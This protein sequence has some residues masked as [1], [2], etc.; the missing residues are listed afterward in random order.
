MVIRRAI[1]G[2]LLSFVFLI[3]FVYMVSGVQMFSQALTANV[4][5]FLQNTV[6]ENSSGDNKIILPAVE[7][8]EPEINAESAISVESD[9]LGTSKIIFEKA[10]E[11][12]LPIASLTKLMTAVIVL[13]S[14]DVSKSIKVDKLAD[15]QAPMK[16]DVKLDDTLPAES[17]LELLLVKSS[18]KSAYALAQ[19]T[20]I[21]KFVG[22]MNQKAKSIGL[23][24]TFFEDPAGLGPNNISTAYDLAKFAEYILKNY[25]KIASI[26]K[27]E[28]LDVPNFGK[29]INTDQLLSEFPEIVCS[30]TGFTTEAKGCLLLVINSQK[31]SNYTINVILGADDRFLEMRKLINWSDEICK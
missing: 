26:S 15:S 19:V 28:E 14:Y 23:K 11:K 18:N 9:L 25:P 30:K 27:A 17:F 24:N 8:V 16:Q 29:I 10:G 13:D 2:F 31:N 5:G 4:S 3:F 6:I 22:L 1:T 20:G 7:A 12:Q 21:Q